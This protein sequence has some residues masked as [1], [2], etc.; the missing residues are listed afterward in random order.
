[1]GGE[2]FARKLVII[3]RACGRGVDRGMVDIE[4][5]IPDRLRGLSVEEF[6]DWLDELDPGM[7]TRVKE[8]NREGMMCWYLGS[9]DLQRDE[10]AIGFEEVPMGDSMTRARESDNVLKIVPK[11]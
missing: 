9:A 10:Y 5:L 7:R 8:A 6:L 1:M 2:D 3:G 4:G 11:W